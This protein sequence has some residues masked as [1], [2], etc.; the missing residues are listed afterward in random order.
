MRTGLTAVLL[1]AACMLR[2]ALCGCD[3]DLLGDDP[4]SRRAFNLLGSHRT[5]DL[6][7][8]STV[9]ASE[10]AHEKPARPRQVL[11]FTASWCGPCQVFKRREVP[12]MERAGWTF[13]D[14]TDAGTHFRV[15]DYD[16]N[17]AL[18][19]M[20]NARSLPVFIAI[21]NDPG[22]DLADATQLSRLV[23]LQTAE[24]LNTLYR[25]ESR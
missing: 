13:G 17:P 25:Q 11:M 15:I 2:V 6:L 12:R 22:G 16:Q 1:L 3:Y 14:E 4:A 19:G 5:F 23:G 7:G 24:S 21:D 18:A 8:A 9:Q 20:F 10:F